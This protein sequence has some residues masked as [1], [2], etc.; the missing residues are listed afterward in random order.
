MT[1]A[2]QLKVKDF[3]FKIK[4]SKNNRIYFENSDGHWFKREFDSNN[5]RIYYEDSY[6]NWIKK[7]YDSKNNRIYYEDSH[8]IIRD[9]RPKGTFGRLALNTL[10]S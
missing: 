3:P 5:N 9:N 7:E 10:S 2:Q 1:I 8:G 6:G 4:D